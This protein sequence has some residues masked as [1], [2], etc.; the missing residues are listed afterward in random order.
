MKSLRD[1]QKCGCFFYHQVE[2]NTLLLSL[3]FPQ[4]M[5]PTV[6]P[7]NLPFLGGL[8]SQQDVPP[9]RAW[10]RAQNRSF[11]LSPPPNHTPFTSYLWPMAPPR[12]ILAKYRL[13]VPGSCVFQICPRVCLLLMHLPWSGDS[14]SMFSDFLC[15][16]FFGFSLHSRAGLCLMMGLTFLWPVPW[17]PLFLT[18]SCCY[19][20]CNNLILLG[21]FWASHLFLLSVAWYDH[22]FVFT[23]GLLCPFGLSFG[24]PWPVCFLWASSA[25]L[26]IPHSH[27]FFT[28]FIGLLWPNNL[29]LI[30][31][32]YGPAINSL[33][34]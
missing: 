18:M 25:L 24:Y 19:S 5:H 23:Y 29:I 14:S 22:C 2:T 34:S 3:S 15:G 10:A 31:G 21:L 28:N 17:F 16:L 33:L 4:G 12:P 1:Q 8:S 20:C 11:L 9:K 13:M 30:L 7:S 32:I 26:L 27:G 6:P